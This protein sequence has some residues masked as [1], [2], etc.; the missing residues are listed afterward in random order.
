MKTFLHAKFWDFH[1][2]RY[3]FENFFIPKKKQ[4]YLIFKEYWT[5]S[6]SFGERV[7]QSNPRS[8]TIVTE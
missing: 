2:F 6:G 1:Q 4:N 3:H 5:P 8:L 7:Q